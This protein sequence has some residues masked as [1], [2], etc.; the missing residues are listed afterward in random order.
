MG[1]DDYIR[2][3]ERPNA[4][5]AFVDKLERERAHREKLEAVILA[6]LNITHKDRYI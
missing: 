6:P 1:Y 2:Q 4:L 5:Q 3:N